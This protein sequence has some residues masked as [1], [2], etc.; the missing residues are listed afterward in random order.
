MPGPRNFPALRRCSL[1]AILWMAA[2]AVVA[3]EYLGRDDFLGL[4]FGESQPQQHTLWLTKEQKAAARAAVGW[5]PAA[6]RLR[7]WQL[8]TRTAWILE[9][10]GKEKPITLGVAIDGRKI[11]RVAV[12][13]FRESRGW[14]IRYPFFTAQFSGLGLAPDGYLSGPVDGITGATLSV[15]ATERMARLALWLDAQVQG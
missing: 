10:I 1:A 11:E 9:D 3:E 7:Y 2:F 14:E 5:A 12:L 6:L 8:G 4:V 15:R 13:A